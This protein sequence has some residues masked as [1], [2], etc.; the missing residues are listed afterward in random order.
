[1]RMKKKERL[2]VLAIAG[3]LACKALEKG[4]SNNEIQEL[5]QAGV[6]SLLK[7]RRQCLKSSA[8]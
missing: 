3:Q 5:V 7:A 8:T 2:L 1:M 6:K 4:Y